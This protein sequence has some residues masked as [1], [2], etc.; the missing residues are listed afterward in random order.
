M[1]VATE[2]PFRFPVQPEHAAFVKMCLQARLEGDTEFFN[3][4]PDTP[5]TKV[6]LSTIKMLEDYDK[7]F[8]GV[9]EKIIMEIID[10]GF[11]ETMQEIV[12]VDYSEVPV[13]ASVFF[14][15][16]KYMARYGSGLYPANRQDMCWILDPA[17]EIIEAIL[18]GSIRWGKAQPLDAGI[19]T[20]HGW[21]SMGDMKVGAE[22]TGVDGKTHHVT[23]VFPQGLREVYKVTFS[24]GS[25]THCCAD[26]LWDV[27]TPAECSKNAPYRTVSL[28]DLMQCYKNK[29]GQRQ[30][31]IPMVQPVVFQETDLPIDPYLL[32]V[33]LGDGDISG[34]N[35]VSFSTVD[36]EILDKVSNSLPAGLRVRHRANYDYSITC[37][38][39]GGCNSIL[40]ALR[41]L[42]CYGKKAHEKY[43]PE[44]YKFAGVQAR[45]SMLWGL[46]DTNGSVERK[47]NKVEFSSA[48]EQLRDDVVF[49]VQSL[50]GVARCSDG[51]T[52]GRRRYRARLAMPACYAPF[53]LAR[54]LRNYR[55]RVRYQP[56][57]AIESI[58]AIGKQQ[59]QCIS[60]DAPASLYVTDD[61]IVTHNTTMAVCMFVYRLYVLSLL[62][63]PQ[64]YFGL[65]EGSEI[66]YGIFNLFKYKTKGMYSRVREMVDH[67]P[68]FKERFARQKANVSDQLRFPRNIEVLSGST[69][70]HALGET[71]IGAILDEMNFM[72][73]ADRRG[74][75]S[76]LEEL[77]QAQKLYTAIRERARLQFL[78]SP[79][80]ITPWMLMLLSQR[81]AQ[82]DFLEVHIKEHGL[83]P[84]TCVVSR[85]IWDVQPEGTYSGKTF[86]VVIGDEVTSSRIVEAGMKPPHDGNLLEVPEEHRTEFELNLDE[87][88]RNVGG[89]ATVAASSLF[90]RREV[91]KTAVKSGKKFGLAHP[92]RTFAV[93]ISDKSPI[94]LQDI[95]KDDVLFSV[96]EGHRRAR[97]NP[98]TPR[99][100]HIDLASTDCSAG[101]A[102]VHYQPEGIY[103][104]VMVDFVLQI[105]P[106]PKGHGE[107]DFEKIVDFVLWLRNNGFTF[108]QVSFD[109]YQS[110]HS[111]T[112][113]R[114][115]GIES[116]YLSVDIT[117]EP[118]IHL[119]GV[120]ESGLMSIYEHQVLTKELSELEHDIT[121]RKVLK[122]SNG[123]KDVADA[124]CGAV[125]GLMP[126]KPSF[127]QPT[128]VQVESGP[129]N[130][131]PIV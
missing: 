98:T 50:G 77:G 12:M 26:H 90:R 102:C 97:I 107:I 92:F 101:I 65:M 47:N 83:D 123:S 10:H 45:L 99:V 64:S 70:L 36:Q 93:T 115:R 29:R 105:N 66:R 73:R 40:G 3:G 31:F 78:A 28:K 27:R 7:R 87:A 103:N 42:G 37:G 76:A 130:V 51:P 58:E 80:G 16:D 6:V 32:G 100:M 23:G 60:T 118:Y 11:S 119:R 48:S 56:S 39:R 96:H 13:P 75:E 14:S 128:K 125:Y 72:R 1:P 61:F 129:T 54:K 116:K 79:G 95:V 127:T 124:L 35:S 15:D 131:V 20:P 8:Q 9:F 110:R 59:V 94:T 126:K 86:F 114:K 4:L 85:A 111:Q 2:H 57:R 117:D 30:A 67:S 122:P 43:V 91:L 71:L 121:I 44:M 106:P 46:M 22:I 109:Q 112:A 21:K 53:S 34:S 74:R 82:T 89:R 104:R 33:L 17:N 49:L 25:F 69:E 62:R 38:Q 19:L 18:T 108:K 41:L 63:S 120:Y 55:P 88:I 52:K 113:L 84:G 81:R 68:Y 24:D 5:R